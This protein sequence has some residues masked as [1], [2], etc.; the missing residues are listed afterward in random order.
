MRHARRNHYRVTGDHWKLLV[1]KLH[2]ADAMRDVINLLGKLV[3]MQ[4][5]AR[6]RWN[7]RF[8]EA[9]V[10]VTVNRRMHQFADL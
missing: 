9:L 10:A 5:R 1:A 2:Q 7:R 4:H 3:T 8:G 6:S